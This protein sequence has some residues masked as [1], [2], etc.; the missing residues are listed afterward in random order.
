MKHSSYIYKEGED[1]FEL[2]LNIHTPLSPTNPKL[3]FAPLQFSSQKTT[4]KI[5]GGALAPPLAPPNYAYD[6]KKSVLSVKQ[7]CHS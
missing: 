2:V 3:L 5:F 6:C 1:W 7:I 4:T